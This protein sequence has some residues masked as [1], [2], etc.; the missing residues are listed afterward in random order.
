MKEGSNNGDKIACSRSVNTTRNNCT[1]DQQLPIKVKKERL[2][3]QV[4]I[5]KKT[6]LYAWYS[7]QNNTPVPV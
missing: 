7:F 6:S 4:L 5:E 1:N 2:Q 3:P